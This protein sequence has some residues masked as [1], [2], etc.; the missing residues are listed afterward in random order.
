[1]CDADPRFI[2][3]FKILERIGLIAY[4]L[5]LPPSLS[6]VHDLF[7]VSMLRKYIM[8]PMHVINY[9]PL[10]IEEDLSYEEKPIKI[11]VWEVKTLCDKNVGFVKVLWRNH[12]TEEVTWEQEEEIK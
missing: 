4:K 11:L 8:D 1:M 7:Y 5:A 10:E 12:Q 2:G 6:S 3:P 9:K